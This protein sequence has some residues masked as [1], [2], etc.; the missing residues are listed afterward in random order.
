MTENSFKQEYLAILLRKWWLIV[1]I[2]GSV[3]VIALLIVLNQAN[4]Y[5]A[6]SRLLIVVPVGSR[7]I[8]TEEGSPEVNFPELSVETLTTLARSG[9]L[10]TDIINELNLKDEETGQPLSVESLEAMMEA[11]YESTGV[12]SQYVRIPILRMTVKG[13]SPKQLKDIADS[14]A[15][16]F[17]K[18]NATLFTSET[19]KSFTFLDSQYND[20]KNTYNSL[21]SDLTKYKKQ[22]PIVLL[23]E[24]LKSSRN[25]FLEV[26]ESLRDKTNELSLSKIELKA[27]NE[28]IKD[29][30][31]NGEWIGFTNELLMNNQNISEQGMLDLST[32]NAYLTNQK[33]HNEYINTNYVT[34]RE[35]DLIQ[36]KEQILQDTQRLVIA[37]QEL[38]VASARKIEL[39]TELSKQNQ[40]IL[41]VKAIDDAT[42]RQQLGLDPN[43][44]TWNQI[45]DLGISTEEINEVYVS[46]SDELSK[47]NVLIS[48]LTEEISNLKSELIVNKKSLLNSE[49]E[50]N[51]ILLVELPI[52]QQQLRSS[53]LS[54]LAELQRYDLT[55]ERQKNLKYL[56]LDL[57][58]Q[59]EAL[60]S[61]YDINKAS[62]ETDESNLLTAEVY[63]AK[64]EKEIST[65]GASFDAIAT[66]RQAARIAKSE[67]EGSIR[68]V[69]SAI[70]PQIPIGPARRSTLIFTGVISLM[71][72]VAMAF[73]LQYI[74]D[75]RIFSR[76]Q[77]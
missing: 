30:S 76:K 22:Y 10:L 35:N 65:I 5:E 23:T 62:L 61:S 15:K 1:M 13:E 40:S 73:L 31:Y 17:E 42:L 57:Q 29:R 32:R 20:A 52:I 4:L 53:Q 36:I 38:V 69:E 34:Q 47:T 70:E 74:Q 3:S 58:A 64:L 9:D 49:L 14:W 67:Q 66:A 11:S 55:V 43:A 8:S 26:N 51:N 72:S 12:G 46:L 39:S 45:R 63:I 19:A 60:R 21:L 6:Q 18:R 37:E 48:G 77:S 33:I 41:L 54:Y 28:E 25:K 50:L 7:V 75:S 16:N 27:V 44:S 56:V 71:L 24:T 59:V 2:T 68:I